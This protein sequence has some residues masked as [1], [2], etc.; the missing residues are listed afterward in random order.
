[1]LGVS[2]VK[3]N[4]PILF[5]LYRLHGISLRSILFL[6]TRMFAVSILSLGW[7]PQPAQLAITERLIIYRHKQ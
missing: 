7:H 3:I 5:Y 1:M 4:P 6:W 2:N